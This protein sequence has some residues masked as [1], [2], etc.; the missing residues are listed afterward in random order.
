[1]PAGTQTPSLED[2][3]S[4]WLRAGLAQ[5]HTSFPA[6]VVVYDPVLQRATVQP[7]IRNRV[8]DIDLGIERPEVTP[9]APIP[10]VP[11]VWP[12][13][14]TWSLHAPLVPGDPVTVLVAERSTDE[15]RTAG[16]PDTIPASGR[17]FNLSDA[18]A[19]PGGRTF[20]PNPVTGP[21]GAAAVDPAAAV[22]AGALV[23]LGG[24]PA[25]LDQVM[26]GTTFEANLSTWLN[27]LTPVITALA[28]SGSPL[29]YIAALVAAASAFAPI[30]A[31][32]V[33]SVSSGVHRSV[34]VFTE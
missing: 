2:L 17:R 12:S 13:G 29:D 1:M 11:I 20:G 5:V 19:F 7:T 25:A 27:G 23:K 18:V 32:F 6:T 33:S 15:W 9:P 14:A 3:L 16:S 8:D 10:N 34:K 21:I 30:H 31:T 22:L 24:G 26:K 4:E 28:T